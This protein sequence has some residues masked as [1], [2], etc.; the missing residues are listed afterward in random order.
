MD[1]TF[2]K[3]KQER[4][5]SLTSVENEVRQ[6]QLLKKIQYVML[7]KTTEGHI[8][9]WSQ[10]KLW[11]WKILM[12][13][14]CGRNGSSAIGLQRTTL[15]LVT[16]LDMLTWVPEFKQNSQEYMHGHIS[17]PIAGLISEGCLNELNAI[18]FDFWYLN[19][20]TLLHTV[21]V[22]NIWKG[23]RKLKFWMV[24]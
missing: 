6:H 18:P 14:S 20:Q 22:S 16:N 13:G 15:V 9:D 1:L 23:K 12:T 24:L 7:I 4:V 17:C 2:L 10:W 5:L 8:L 21:A 11:M 3:F 19:F